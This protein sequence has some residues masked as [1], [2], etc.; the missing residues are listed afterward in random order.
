MNDTPP[1]PS[2]THQD[3]SIA[4]FIE[5]NDS[6]RLLAMRQIVE[7]AF[8]SF[9]PG[10]TAEVLHLAKL[11]RNLNLTRARATELA[12]A[13]IIVEIE[14]RKCLQTGRRAIVWQYV[15]DPDKRVL[16][17]KADKKSQ[18]LKA[19]CDTLDPMINGVEPDESLRRI[20]LKLLIE[21]ARA[22]ITPRR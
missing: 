11:D 9:A 4:A 2:P 13:G 7:R 16:R 17:S 19:F 15:A 10:T 3:T 21:D 22:L 1:I 5:E 20:E 8:A 18:L 12:D 14:S 6:G